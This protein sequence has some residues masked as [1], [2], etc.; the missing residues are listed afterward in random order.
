MLPYKHKILGIDKI[1]TPNFALLRFAAGAAQRRAL[2]VMPYLL[3][4]VAQVA[5]ERVVWQKYNW[6][7]T[8]YENATSC[9]VA[10]FDGV[11]TRRLWRQNVWD[12]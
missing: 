7:D 11:L 3:M 5:N 1:K 4:I 2:I 9:Y 10:S 6:E 12:D 8:D